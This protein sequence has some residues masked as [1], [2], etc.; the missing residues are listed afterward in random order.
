MCPAAGGGKS[1][2]SV[3]SASHE[4]VDFRPGHE[5]KRP[6]LPRLSEPEDRNASRATEPRRSGE[7]GNTKRRSHAS[8]GVR[9][10]S[11][12]GVEF[13]DAPRR[14]GE[15]ATFARGP[16]GGLPSGSAGTAAPGSDH[17]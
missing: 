7:S 11:G 8:A 15:R 17:Q 13:E 16:E 12:T 4:P 1:K 14:S 2:S 3:D 10:D 9:S 5:E 6:G